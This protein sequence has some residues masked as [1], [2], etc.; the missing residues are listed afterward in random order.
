M[1]KISP[2][3]LSGNLLNLSAE[4]ELMNKAGADLIHIDIMDGIFVPNITAGIDIVSAIKSETDIPLDVHLMIHKP[5]RYIEEFV[6]SGADILTVHQ[7]GCV[8]LHRTAERIRELGASP[9]VAVNPATPISIL[10]DILDYVDLVLIMSVD[11]GFSGQEFIYSSLFKIEKMHR[12]IS[13][14]ELK[15]LI[16]VDG[17]VKILNIADV[18]NSGANIIVSGSG[19]FKTGDPVKAVADMRRRI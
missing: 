4:L 17:G 11:P 19:I 2:S 18:A 5:E 7:E 15:T 8:H 1:K 6:K 3:I 16:E 13:Q 14:R 9:G 10:D 12:I